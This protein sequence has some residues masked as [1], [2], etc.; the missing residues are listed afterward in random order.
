MVHFRSKALG[1]KNTVEEKDMADVS[2]IY[3]VVDMKAEKTIGL[4]DKMLEW[5]NAI[6]DH[7]WRFICNMNSLPMNSKG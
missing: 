2:E 4:V 5:C 6:M 3:L 1:I 7:N